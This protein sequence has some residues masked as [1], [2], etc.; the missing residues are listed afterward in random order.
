MGKMK[1]IVNWLEEKCV[2]VF[3][4]KDLKGRKSLDFLGEDD[5][6]MYIKSIG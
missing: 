5:I 6:K 4:G 2:Q 3:G 1:L